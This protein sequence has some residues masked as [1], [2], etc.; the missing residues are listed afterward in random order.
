VQ[1]GA[2]FKQ[3]SWF[4]TVINSGPTG[5]AVL[6]VRPTAICVVGTAIN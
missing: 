6:T 4:F 2:Q 1:S 5:S 3:Q